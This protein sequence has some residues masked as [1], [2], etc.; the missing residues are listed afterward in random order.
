M[1]IT[2]GYKNPALSTVL[3]ALTHVQKVIVPPGVIQHFIN[4]SEDTALSCEYARSVTP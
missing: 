4:T 3:V 1:S 2:G